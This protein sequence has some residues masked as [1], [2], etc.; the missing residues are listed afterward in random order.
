[1]SLPL[2]IAFRAGALALIAAASLHGRALAQVTFASTG[3]AAE[4]TYAADVATIIQNH[5][6]VCHR[7]GG[8]GPMD[9]LTY[10]DARRYARRIREQVGSGLMP[11]YYY[12]RD[13]GIQ[14]LQHD[15]RL[16]PEQISTVVAWVDQGAPL[17]DPA[18][19]PPLPDLNPPDEWAFVPE[20]GQPD[21]IIPSTPI[22]VPVGGM[23]MMHW[24][25]VPSGLAED[26][27]IRAIQVKPAG[28]A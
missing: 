28:A 19:V 14:Q 1:M 12:D 26:R 7:P 6:V 4:V 9:L 13:I 24:P 23:D 17:G 16:T 27:C 10:E 5:C 11:P 22:D 20:Y 3:T 18:D 25:I 15:W 8:I 21:L 2:R